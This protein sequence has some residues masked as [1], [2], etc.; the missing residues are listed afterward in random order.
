MTSP[1]RYLWR[2]LG[3]L[4]AV[5]A[6]AVLLSGALGH[7]FASNPV[8]NSIILGVLL[9]GI[10][11][12]VGRCWCCG[13]R[14]SGWST[15]R[16]PRPGA[17]AQPAPKLLGPMASMFAARRADRLSLSGRPCGACWTAS[18]PAW[19]SSARCRAT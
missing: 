10:A 11:W 8:L 9:V 17:P 19:T 18:R 7:A 1:L 15:F 16:S 6:V 2:M 4:L 14:W 13:R 5:A 3:F 12:T